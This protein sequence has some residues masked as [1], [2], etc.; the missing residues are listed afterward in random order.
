M[1]IKKYISF[2]LF[3]LPLLLLSLDASAYNFNA[4][5]EKGAQEFQIFQGCQRYTLSR[6]VV[7]PRGRSGHIITDGKSQLMSFRTR[8]NA[9]RALNL[10]H[11]HQLAQECYLDRE[12]EVFRYFLTDESRLPYQNIDQE[13]CTEI[14]FLEIESFR[15]IF[16][17]YYRLSSLYSDEYGQFQAVEIEVFNSFDQAQ[18]ARDLLYLFRASKICF[19]TSARNPE[20]RYFRL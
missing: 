13:I 2:K 3:I 14:D 20:F 5:T 7:R 6:L 17:T 18:E 4:R 11:A 19:N 16:R 15:R 1:Q 9:V 10:I 12:N 8:E